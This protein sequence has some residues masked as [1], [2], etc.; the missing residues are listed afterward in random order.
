MGY[1]RVGTKELC[2][3]P[4]NTFNKMRVEYSVQTKFRRVQV[5]VTR[6]RVIVVDHGTHLVTSCIYEN[7][8]P[9]VI[10]SID[11]HKSVQ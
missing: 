2:E 5:E 11:S 9:L 6:G 4:R 8:P 10:Q 1:A 7:A 3:N